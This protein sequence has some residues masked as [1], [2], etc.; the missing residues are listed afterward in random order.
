VRKLEA[1]ASIKKASNRQSL[2]KVEGTEAEI[3]KTFKKAILA[4]LAIHTPERL[5]TN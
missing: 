2:A 4:L 5:F 3:R 1:V